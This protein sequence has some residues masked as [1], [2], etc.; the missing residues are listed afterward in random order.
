VRIDLRWLE[1]DKETA[2]IKQARAEKRRYEPDTLEN[3]E[4]P[5][6]LLARLRSVL[7]IT[8][9]KHTLSQTLRRSIAF[10]HYP[11]LER[12]YNHGMQL[13]EVFELTGAEQA[14]KR[15]KEWVELTWSNKEEAFYT[16]ASTVEAHFENILNYFQH[17]STNAGAESFNAKIKRF[18]ANQRGVQDVNFF[19][20]RLEKLF[21]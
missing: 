3:D 18:R 17:R 7:M 14:R 2:A 15:L 12:A 1:L 13:R 9:N 16:V 20:F 11:Q 5:R 21:A 10:Q 19:L 8:K 4:T 6:Q